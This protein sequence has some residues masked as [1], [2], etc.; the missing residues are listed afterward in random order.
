M[1]LPLRLILLVLGTA[2]ALSGEPTTAALI[3]AWRASDLAVL[4]DGDA[5][6]SWRSISNR[7]LT[8]SLT[9]QP[10]LRKGVTPV[11]GEAVRFNL[12]WLRIPA[13]SPVAGLT[14]FSIALVFR[15]GAVGGNN[16]SQWYGKSGIVDAEEGGVTR[17]WGVV[18]DQNG[19][20]GLGIGAPDLTVY[21]TSAP[22]LMDTNYHAAV[23]SWGGGIQTIY[24]DNLWTNSISGASALSRNDAGFSLGA[25]HTGAG[26]ATQ[27]FVGDLVEIRFYDTNLTGSGAAAVIREL[28]DTRLTPGVPIIRSFSAM[29]GQILIGSPVVLS[30]NATDVSGVRIDPGAGW[31]SAAAGSVQVFPR[32]NTTY[33]L[34]ATNTLGVRTA[35]VTVLVDQGIPVADNQ[36]V[37]TLIDTPLPVHLTGS[38]PQG[39]NITYAVVTA[40]LNGTLT[41]SPPVLTY[42]AALHFVGNDQFTF[43]VNDGEFDSPPATI[44]IR[45]LAPPT[46][47]SAIVLSTTN[48]SAGAAP[49]SFIASLRAIDVNP[50]DT[51]SFLLISGVG[52]AAQF[53]LTGTQ[54][55]A[56]SGFLGGPGRNYTIRVRATDNT[57]LW[58]EHDLFLSVAPTAPGVVINEV[59]YN[60]PDNTVREEFIELQNPTTLDVDVS[61]WR[62][63]GVVEL[64]IPPGQVIHPGGFLVLAQDPATI[65]SRYGVFALGPWTGNLS[66]DG[67]TITLLDASG[68]KINEVSYSPE[69]PWPVGA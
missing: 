45:V 40:P 43:K 62:L 4:N 38:D 58:L 57:G 47:P 30:W 13:N 56:S 68:Q 36:S 63:T 27:R 6:G 67:D 64:A 22:S 69:F 50:D 41:G 15:A 10:L 2:A 42:T 17:D 12:D 65:L 20:L 55:S 28:V 11:G 8:G 54:L 53:V 26:G 39:S 49:G 1:P 59:H 60:P 44:G 9:D 33:T 66:S 25:T 61:L 14:N 19:K 24:V 48:I 18:I 23:V 51:H 5:I 46:A 52:D 35:Q 32:A 31:M 16:S 21:S 7:I 34:T 29:P 3:D 37:N